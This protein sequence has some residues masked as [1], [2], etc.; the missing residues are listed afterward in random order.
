MDF[1]ASCMSELFHLQH[2]P[3]DT[4]VPYGEGG[5]RDLKE[6][7]LGDGVESTALQQ[8][9]VSVWVLESEKKKKR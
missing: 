7:P 9:Q 8:T 4:L 5:F 3:S 1:G 2:K 6:I